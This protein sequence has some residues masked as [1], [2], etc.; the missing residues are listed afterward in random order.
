MSYANSF[1]NILQ[2]PLIALGASQEIRVADVS[3]TLGTGAAES[4]VWT[5]PDFGLGAFYVTKIL[6]TNATVAPTIGVTFSLQVKSAGPVYN[7]I[8]TGPASLADLSNNGKYVIL[9]ADSGALKADIGTDIVVTP[10][11]TGTTT[12]V[13]ITVF[14]MFFI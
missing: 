5:V 3:V 12:Q 14:G 9:G 11:G 10:S 1:N 13:N 7:T 8:I 4:F 2:R 6:V